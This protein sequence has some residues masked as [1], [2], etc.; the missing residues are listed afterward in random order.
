MIPSV[1][2]A[3]TIRKTAEMGHEI[4]YHYET[5][6]QTNGDI[7][8]AIELFGEELQR[9]RGVAEVKTASM[10]GSPLKPW[11]NRDI[12]QQAQ[13]A[14][15]GLLGEAYLN[16]DYSLSCNITAIRGGHGIP[17]AI[18]SVTMWHIPRKSLLKRTDELIQ[19]IQT[20]S[21][22]ATVYF[23]AS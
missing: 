10:H 11:D 2:D 19:L 16:L 1:Y 8:C 18:T 3:E 17:V 20:Q 6:A 14:D 5:M 9:L 4:G 21:I 7:N 23:D 22:S 13:P 15:F 12:W